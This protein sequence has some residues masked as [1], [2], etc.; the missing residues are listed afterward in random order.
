[1]KVS[2]NILSYRYKKDFLINKSR[3]NKISEYL[4]KFVIDSHSSCPLCSSNEC[5]NIAEVDRVGFPCDTL[6]CNKCSLVFNNSF[7]QN[8]ESLYSR[9]FSYERWEDPH[10]SFKKRTR[11]DAFSWRR[12]NFLKQFIKNKDTQTRILEIGC[13]DGCN[14]YPFFKEGASTIGCDY[15]ED[16]LLPGREIGLDLRKGDFMEVLDQ[17][18]TFDVIMLVHSFEHFLDLTQQIERIKNFC[19]DETIIYVEVPGIKNW[20]RIKSDSLSQ[21]GF[22]SSNNFLDYIQYQHN[23]NFELRTLT[24][25]W[26]GCGFELLYGDEWVRAIFKSAKNIHLESNHQFD[27]FKYLSE[28]EK[29][30]LFSKDHL[31]E[32]KAN[33]K[34]L[35]GF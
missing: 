26:S 7:I 23:Y 15:S 16:F 10:E 32:I 17:D 14:L 9:D 20:N 29:D 1:M 30:Y 12:Y 25:F 24:Q 19:S 4:N 3:F 34:D 21:D 8:I 28:I 6:I 33:L 11:K 35:I 13:G 31:R 18:Y 22:A 27:I 2:K 5:T